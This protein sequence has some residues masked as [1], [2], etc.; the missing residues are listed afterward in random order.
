LK[1]VESAVTSRAL[2]AYSLGLFVTLVGAALI[3][4]AHPLQVMTPVP[5]AAPQISVRRV[6]LLPPPPTAFQVESAMNSRQLLDRW[7]P[8][9]E[10]AAKR[11]RVPA[12]WI[13]VVMQ[14]E[15]GGRTILAEGQPIVSSAGAM[16]IMQMMPDTYSEMAAQYGLGRDP[17]DPHDNIFA[18]AGYLRWL[19]GKYGYPAMF[20][21]Y[22]DGPG[23]YEDYLHGRVLPAETRAYVKAV[24]GGPGLAMAAKTVP[25]QLTRPDG[26]MM[27]VEA[28]SVSAVRAALPGEYASSVHAV[29]SM[30]RVRQGVC[31]EV[32]SVVER[33]RQNGAKL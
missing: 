10:G 19:H 29:V 15:S 3:V 9:I 5:E 11:F 25:V 20:A 4:M 16:G 8:L 24:A 6:D 28:A 33:L 22:N 12:A 2:S 18:A 31:E 23:N 32:A 21:A 1:P 14:R 26:T 7:N 17:F 13:R 27:A 30:G